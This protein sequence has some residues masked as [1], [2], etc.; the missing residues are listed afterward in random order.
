MVWWKKG[1]IFTN[2]WSNRH[3]FFKCFIDKLFDLS[4]VHLSCVY[5][6]ELLSKRRTLVKGLVCPG[7]SCLQ[8][9]LSGLPNLIPS[10]GFRGKWLISSWIEQHVSIRLLCR[11]A[12]LLLFQLLNL[13]QKVLFKAG[14]L[15]DVVLGW[16]EISEFVVNGLVYLTLTS[17]PG[18]EE[19][20]SRYGMLVIED[21]LRTLL[22]VSDWLLYSRDVLGA[23]W[24]SHSFV[25][26]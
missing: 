16:W 18:R 12:M 21:L 10:W 20:G 26:Y 6:A 11:D 2:T 7:P 15:V 19:F 5:V 8:C 23:C 25:L 9:S 24:V 4:S 14:C 22:V 3:L 13:L 1:R 17:V